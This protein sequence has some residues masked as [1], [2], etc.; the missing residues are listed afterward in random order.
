MLFVDGV[1]VI[2]D[3]IAG[4]I[5]ASMIC[6]DDGVA[7]TCCLLLF[8]AVDGVVV[9]VDCIVGCI[10]DGVVFSCSNKIRE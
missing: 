3:C 2:V 5:V 1:V 6:I 7:F 4:C 9:I 10:Y 8:V